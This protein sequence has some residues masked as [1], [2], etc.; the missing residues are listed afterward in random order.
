MPIS[1][2]TAHLQKE[3]LYRDVTQLKSAVATFVGLDE[4]LFYLV[5]KLKLSTWKPRLYRHTI[6]PL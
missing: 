5:I 6:V 4:K 1:E 2:S 3:T